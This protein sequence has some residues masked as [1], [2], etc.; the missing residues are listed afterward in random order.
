MHD[1]KTVVEYEAGNV[2]HDTKML[3]KK[4]REERGRRAKASPKLGIFDEKLI[5]PSTLI[6]NIPYISKSDVT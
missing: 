3:V 4:F 1:P 6:T 5:K 2:N